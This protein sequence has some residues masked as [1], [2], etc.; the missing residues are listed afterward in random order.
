MNTIIDLYN[1]QVKMYITNHWKV[2]TALHK[3]NGIIYHIKVPYGVVNT[4]VYIFA[5]TID[6]W[7]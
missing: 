7:L 1:K 6:T 3:P 2:A 4:F 5:K